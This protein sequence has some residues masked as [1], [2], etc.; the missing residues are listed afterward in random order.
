MDS[1]VEREHDKS[2]EDVNDA[3]V[4][5]VEP[6]LDE[7]AKDVNDAAVENTVEIKYKYPVVK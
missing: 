4:E 1:T 6:Q 7:P 2:A 5:N 3:A